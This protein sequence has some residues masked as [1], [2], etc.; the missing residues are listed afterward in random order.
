MWRQ[1]SYLE[2]LT[3]VVTLPSLIL[4]LSLSGVTSSIR[5]ALQLIHLNTPRLFNL[6]I[7]QIVSLGLKIYDAHTNLPAHGPAFTNLP[8]RSPT[9]RNSLL[10]V[11]LYRP[12]HRFTVQA[13]SP[14]PKPTNRTLLHHYGGSAFIA[15]RQ[16]LTNPLLQGLLHG[17]AHLAARHHAVQA[18]PYCSY[19]LAATPVSPS[20]IS[21]AKFYY[22]QHPTQIGLLPQAIPVVHKY[23]SQIKVTPL[24]IYSPHMVQVSFIHSCQVP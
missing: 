13:S 21:V 5:F 6:P 3:Q 22:F 14:D 15:R 9:L 20:D 17:G 7:T 1:W 4:A 18:Y 8:A 24:I 19:R 23:T 16:A 2:F 12:A 11:L 10:V